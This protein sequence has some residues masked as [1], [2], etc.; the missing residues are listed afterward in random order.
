[1]A[2]TKVIPAGGG[3]QLLLTL[4]DGTVTITRHGGAAA[5]ETLT[6]AGVEVVLVV[7]ALTAHARRSRYGQ[8]A[9]LWAPEA[10]E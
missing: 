9:A 8:Q 7:N 6:L 2:R 4:D 10:A 5:G 3:S 1:M